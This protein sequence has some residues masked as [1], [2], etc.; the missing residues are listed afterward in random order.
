MARPKGTKRPNLE[1]IELVAVCTALNRTDKQKLQRLAR[2]EGKTD[3]A[4]LRMVLENYFKGV[5]I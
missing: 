1:K 5:R 3:K 4:Y 2:Q